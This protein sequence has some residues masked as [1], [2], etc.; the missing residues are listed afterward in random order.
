MVLVV[1]EGSAERR[2]PRWGLA[3]GLFVVVSGAIFGLA[4]LVP[5]E[6]KADISAG[7]GGDATR[8][9]ALFAAN[10]AGCHGDDGAG[11]GIGPKLADVPREPA[12]IASVV[13]TGRGAMPAGLVTGGD[14]ADVVAYVASI[15]GGATAPPA[16]AART[17][18][19]TVTFGG[20]RLQTIRITLNEPAPEGWAVWVDGP[21][22]RR[23]VASIAANERAL[24][25]PATDPGSLATGHDAVLVGP[26]ADTPVLRADISGL[27]ELFVSAP[28]AA[29][30]ASLVGGLDSQVDILRQHIRFLRK[31][32]DEKNLAN[33]R[34]HGEH[35][36]NIV[37]GEPLADVDG[38]G[39]PSNPGDGVGLLG[40]ANRDGYLPRILDLTDPPPASGTALATALTAIAREGQRCG[41][42]PSVAGGRAC[43]Q[44]IAARDADVARLS[45][46]MRTEVRAATT[47]LL[48]RNP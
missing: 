10:C 48:L 29:G 23:L 14:A 11:G 12:A 16:P 42:A 37:R 19:G 9:Q 36:V 2:P 32:L 8:G 21:A 6:P 13:A 47:V 45:A 24:T 20:D 40:Q 4:K 25:L 1:S 39:D 41:T 38:N 3:A 35:M 34:F 18:G 26:S 33:I 17:E 46:A 22:G 27:G 15:G 30:G 28:A 31:A 5:F 43:V 7:A 44:A